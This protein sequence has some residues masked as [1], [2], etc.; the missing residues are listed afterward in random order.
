MSTLETIQSKIETY[1]DSWNGWKRS[2]KGKFRTKM[3]KDL[4]R[5]ITNLKEQ[6]RELRISTK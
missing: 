2:Q 4:R 5:K 1:T 3:L 6:Q